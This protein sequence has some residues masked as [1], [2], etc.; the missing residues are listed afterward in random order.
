MKYVFKNPLFDSEGKFIFTDELKANW[1]KA[2]KSG[3]FKQYGGSLIKSQGS[4][5]MCCLGVLAHIHPHLSIGIDYDGETNPYGCIV[6][7]NSVSYE[8]FNEMKIHA[9]CPLDL[10][11]T[12]DAGYE[13]GVEDY[14]EV[15]PLIQ[16][17]ETINN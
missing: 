15:I 4:M 7:G 12:N 17:L 1:L 3:E 9:N 13:N 5:S 2:L 10:S 16:Q 6:N 8:P 11:T 14:S